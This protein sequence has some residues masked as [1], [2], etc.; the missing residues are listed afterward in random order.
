MPE[1]N[2]DDEQVR[3]RQRRPENDSCQGDPASQGWPGLGASVRAE[4]IKG[5]KYDG[6]LRLGLLLSENQ[7][8]ALD[9]HTAPRR[10]LARKGEKAL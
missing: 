10:T 4:V 1:R 6:L 9:T 3:Q 8:K 7:A 5:P 2:W